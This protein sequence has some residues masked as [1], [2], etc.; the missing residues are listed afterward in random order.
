MYCLQYQKHLLI[1]VH[2]GRLL[3]PMRST[4]APSVAPLFFA[5]LLQMDDVC[6]LKRQAVG[7]FQRLHS[8]FHSLA[9]SVVSKIRSRWRLGSMLAR[10]PS[11][12]DRLTQ[13]VSHDAL[14]LVILVQVIEYH[15]LQVDVLPSL[16]ALLDAEAKVSLDRI[17][18][19]YLLR[20]PLHDVFV[21]ETRLG[22]ENLTKCTHLR[23]VLLSRECDVAS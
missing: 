8:T 7:C 16:E 15:E 18:L 9:G 12:D 23:K 10:M 5:F 11:G 4:H 20:Y 19:E 21:A 3:F 13:S 22:P 2:C 17:L 6:T 14:R 1:F